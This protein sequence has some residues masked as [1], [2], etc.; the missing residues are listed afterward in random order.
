MKKIFY[1]LFL[2]TIFSSCA[3]KK[4]IIYFQPDAASLEESYA[5]NAPK[6]QP[7][8][9][10]AISVTADDVKAT[11]PFNQVSSY[12]GVGGGVQSTS[13]FIP[14]YV[15]GTKGTIDFP[16]LGEVAL[17]GKTRAQ[18]VEYLKNEV[19]KYIVNPGVS[20]EIR[21]FRIT[22]LGEVKT[23]GTYP[24]TNDRI[25]ILEALGIAG[26]LTINGIRKN[27]LVIREQNGI[28]KEYRVDLTQRSALNSPVYYLAQNDVIYV[29][30]NGAKI[31]SSKYTQNTT[32]FVSI[33][34]VIISVI[35]VLTR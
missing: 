5:I 16:L 14:T 17:A 6:L 3:S 8:D 23:P 35:S 21:N 19:S 34:G 12:Q 27:I 25:T 10:L 7:G 9:I 32:V 26:D 13:P 11:L 30:P 31:Q 22:V 33:A 28:K 2:L 15:I 24:I 1:F 4:D 29:E 18:A 20:I